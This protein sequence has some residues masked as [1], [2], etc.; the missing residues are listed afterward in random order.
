MPDDRLISADNLI[1]ILYQAG[2]NFL[3]DIA[4]AADSE[5]PRLDLSYEVRRVIDSEDQADR[6][7][8]LLS[9]S[10]AARLQIVEYLFR[11]L[12]YGS[13]LDPRAYSKIEYLQMAV[14]QILP[15]KRDSLGLRHGLS[16]Q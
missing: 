11:Y 12:E 3:F 7:D 6:P 1:R 5:T 10:H 9:I 13:N 15:V 2:K 8:Q 4:S 14:A 16:F